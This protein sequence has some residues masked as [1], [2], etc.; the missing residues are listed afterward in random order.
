[1][2]TGKWRAVI[3]RPSRLLPFR[4]EAAFGAGLWAVQRPDAAD[5]L[6]LWAIEAAAD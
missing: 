3:D 1:M 2:G 6:C 5:F 4:P